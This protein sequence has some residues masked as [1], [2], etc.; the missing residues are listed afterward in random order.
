MTKLTP[1][2]TFRGSVDRYRTGN[3]TWLTFAIL[4]I[5]ITS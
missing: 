5:D 1:S 3:T 2:T 4:K